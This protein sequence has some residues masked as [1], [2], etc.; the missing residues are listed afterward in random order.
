MEA[1]TLKVQL[2]GL[3]SLVTRLTSGFNVWGGGLDGQRRGQFYVLTYTAADGSGWKKKRF[4][5]ANDLA[6]EMLRKTGGG[7]LFTVDPPN[8]PKAA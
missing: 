8:E 6:W 7:C 5:N 4:K 2:E 1:T 3:N